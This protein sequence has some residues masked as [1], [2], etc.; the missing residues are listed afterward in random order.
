MRVNQGAYP[1]H[2]YVLAFL[3]IAYNKL[4]RNREALVLL[5]KAEQTSTQYNHQLHTGI[6][7]LEKELHGR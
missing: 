3:G 4:G 6:A 1:D 5:K 2:P 7:E